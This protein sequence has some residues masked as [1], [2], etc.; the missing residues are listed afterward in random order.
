MQSIIGGTAGKVWKL[1]EKEGEM[2]V[3]QVTRKLNV[4]AFTTTAAIGW[5][6]REAKVIVSRKRSAAVMYL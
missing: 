1:L 5:L 6:A 4:D 3:T 2:S